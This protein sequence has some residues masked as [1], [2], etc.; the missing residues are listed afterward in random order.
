MSTPFFPQD[1]IASAPAPSEPETVSSLSERYDERAP[2]VCTYCGTERRG[3]Y[4]SNCGQRFRDEPLTFKELV[5]QMGRGFFDLDEGLLYTVWVA[6][7]N[8]GT[9]A[10]RFLDGETRRFVSPIGYLLFGVTVA[11]VVYWSLR[12]SYIAFVADFLQS[13]LWRPDAMTDADLLEGLSRFGV[14]TFQEYGEFIFSIQTQ[15]LTG[16][17]LLSAL[18]AALGLYVIFR[19]RTL[20]EILAFQLYVIGQ[21]TMYNAVLVSASAL[22]G[23]LLFMGLQFPGQILLQGWAATGLYERSLKTAVLAAVAF[24][25]SLIALGLLGAGL[26]ILAV[27][28]WNAGIAG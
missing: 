24:V 14:T 7:L 16:L 8:P 23:S 15:Y 20:A 22:T 1:A 28:L 13:P 18:P 12:D 6:T 19:G 5:R 10:R 17:S 2:E 11:F 3:H 25:G 9:A 21:F 4:C 26:A 27:T